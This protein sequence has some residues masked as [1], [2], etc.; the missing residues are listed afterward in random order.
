M[1]IV[2]ICFWLFVALFMLDLSFLFLNVYFHFGP[3]FLGAVDTYHVNTKHF[4]IVVWKLVSCEYLRDGITWYFFFQPGSH[5]FS[6]ILQSTKIHQSVLSLSQPLA[7]ETR[8][9]RNICEQ[10]ESERGER[11]G[12]RQE[13]HHRMTLK[14]IIRHGAKTWRHFFLSNCPT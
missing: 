10:K 13:T 11:V 14:R 9:K 2:L 4:K 6:L 12:Y 3:D 8:P 5:P 7:K 1:Q